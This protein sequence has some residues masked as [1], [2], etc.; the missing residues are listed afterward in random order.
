MGDALEAARQRMIAKRFGGNAQGAKTGGAGSMKLK[1]KA[2]LKSEGDDKKLSA[3]LKKMQATP[4]AN[5]EEVNI[6]KSDGNVI[7]IRQPKITASIP[8]NTFA[9]SGRGEDKPL[10]DLLPGILSQLGPESMEKLKEYAAAMG[11]AQGAAGGADEDDDDDEVPDL[12]EN[13]E[14]AAAVADNLD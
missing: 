11:A 4:L 5:I 2:P 3:I 8:S 12:V 10:T 13:F 1:A 7:N 14:E 9:I 6:F